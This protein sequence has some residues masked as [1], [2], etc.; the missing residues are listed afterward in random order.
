M[1]WYMQL[2]MESR[3]HVLVLSEQCALDLDGET[4]PSVQVQGNCTRSIK[5]P[6]AAASTVAPGRCVLTMASDF[7]SWYSVPA[8]AAV[9]LDGLHVHTLEPTAVT[10]L[11]M[12]IDWTPDTAAARLYMTN[13]TLQSGL[14][15]LWLEADAYVAGVHR[16]PQ[17]R[18]ICRPGFSQ[19]R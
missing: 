5:A 14:T 15:Q 13:V 16:A 4:S 9:W 18:Y 7:L 10:S 12:S 8:A 17:S 11:G 1:R 19:A 2:H 6:P 3:Q